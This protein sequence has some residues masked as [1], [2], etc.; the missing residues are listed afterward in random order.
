MSDIAPDSFE[1]S[2]QSL[3]FKCAH[4]CT[5]PNSFF[6]VILVLQTIIRLFQLVFFNTQK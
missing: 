2:P 1:V 3:C 5:S 4:L 6:V